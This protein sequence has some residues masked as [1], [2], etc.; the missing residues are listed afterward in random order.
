MCVSDEYRENSLE[1]VVVGNTEVKWSRNE[2][3]C[4]FCY[5]VFTGI[6]DLLGHLKMSHEGKGI[7][8]C[9]YCKSM[10]LSENLQNEHIKEQHPKHFFIYCI[11]CRK[12]FKD[13]NSLKVHQDNCSETYKYQC[14][15]CLQGFLTRRSMTLH[16]GK[17][18]HKGMI[19]RLCNKKFLDR[20]E[21]L[22]HTPLGADR[23]KEK[24]H[25]CHVC[26]KKFLSYSLL[27]KHV[28]GQHEQEETEKL[29]SICGWMTTKTS[30]FKYHMKSHEL[31]CKDCGFSCGK[32]SDFAR[33]L[34]SYR[35]RACPK[36][37]RVLLGT[38]AMKHHFK[39]CKELTNKT[40]K[41]VSDF[42]MIDE[43]QSID[44]FKCSGCKKNL[45]G[46]SA[47]RHLDAND[48]CSQ[49][50]R[51]KYCSCTFIETSVL[52]D[53]EA[54]H[55]GPWVCYYCL[56]G[57]LKWDKLCDHVKQH[58]KKRKQKMRRLKNMDKDVKNKDVEDVP[59]A[60]IKDHEAE[61]EQEYNNEEKGM[62]EE[63]NHTDKETG[64]VEDENMLHAKETESHY[65]NMKRN[66]ETEVQDENIADVGETELENED[67][68]Y[69]VE[70]EIQ[71]ENLVV[72]RE[73]A[74]SED[75]IL[76]D[77]REN[78]QVDEDEILIDT[79]VRETVQVE[80]QQKETQKLEQKKFIKH[81]DAK[82]KMKTKHVCHVCQK[83][84]SNYLVLEK[85][86]QDQ[87]EQDETE[88]LC[89]ICG[90][91]TTEKT[92]FMQHMK[93]HKLGCDDCGF[94]CSNPSDYARHLASH[95][96]RSCPKCHRVMSGTKAMKN[97]LRK[98]KQ[99]IN[100]A[101]NNVNDFGM[102]DEL[103]SNDE[104]RC[105]GCKKNLKSA[106]A[107]KHFDLNDHCSQCHRCKYCSR[108][109][110]ETHVLKEHEATH[111]GPWVCHYCLKGFLQWDKI[112][113]HVKQ[114]A[115]KR[116]Q[117]I[118]HHKKLDKDV[119]NKDEEDVP[120][121]ETKDTEGQIEEKVNEEKGI[122]EEINH[123]AKEMEE[124]ER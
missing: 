114:H 39:T 16:L 88:K 76:I 44:E 85:H 54:T 36:C 86:I 9:G 19:C 75:E 67:M 41:N 6:T 13:V 106:C 124:T 104:F 89:S 46:A 113:D 82:R 42:E 103:Q 110:V 73:T 87:H 100:E 90:W 3:V 56:R 26:Q 34:A 63:I 77:V 107:T 99:V 29:C 55:T 27:K 65:E 119:K 70:T 79:D 91:M 20:K 83:K 111:I 80:E 84:F 11:A 2:F 53:H 121:A 21:F 115:K 112:C 92:S 12:A 74:Q 123:T 101:S 18:P 33:H 14:G 71:D 22:K 96:P 25:V 108:T 49:C 35:P 45:K 109:F 43:L 40:S 72:F 37:N 57:F 1:N 64:D 94:I 122:N 93:S 48:N 118:R 78:F 32:P 98:C 7:Y 5:Q 47:L 117:K 66:K 61:M 17:K 8:P 23:K 52:K 10:F 15:T 58:A 31:G 50:H 51:C 69:V 38:Q 30:A 62:S 24:K 102:M 28:Q 95:Q 60:E 120:E 105:S 4:D 116:E 81:L 97:H 59:E 68:V